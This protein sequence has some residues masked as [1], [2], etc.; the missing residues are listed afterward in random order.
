MKTAIELIA[1]ERQRQIEVEGWTKQH[2][3]IHKDGELVAAALCYIDAPNIKG[4]PPF[5]PWDFEW[6]KPTPNDRVRE[7]VKAGALLMA[8]QD[9]LVFEIDQLLN[10]ARLIGK[11]S[12]E[13]N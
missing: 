12:S 7:L 9:R 10:T 5:W 2:D 1:D 8:E 3:L 11:A 13:E 4:M 6:F